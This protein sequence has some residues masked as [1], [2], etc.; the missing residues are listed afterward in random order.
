LQE[1]QNG[2]IES[3]EIKTQLVL[4]EAQ[5]LRDTGAP[6][7]AY[8]ILTAALAKQPESI[9]LRYDR[10]MIAD[11]LDLVDEME[12]DLRTVMTIKP[13]HAHAYNALGYS[14]AERGI[15]LDE[16]L[17]LIQK[18]VALAPE[19][20]YILDSLGW[21]QFRLKRSDEALATLTRAYSMRSDPEI[22]AHLGEVLWAKGNRLDAQQLWKRA[23]IENPENAAL[24]SMI[25][26]FKE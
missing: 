16:A 9:A 12:R 1:A 15:R 14:F 2:D 17:A 7:D 8:N 4:A 23:L 26:R 24:L 3:A 25:E 5:L 20:A 21:V 10:A 22:A 19:D 13:D 6:K 11:R 18:A